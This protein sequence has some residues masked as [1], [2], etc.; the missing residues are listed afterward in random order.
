MIQETEKLKRRKGKQCHFFMLSVL[1]LI[2]RFPADM[3]RICFHARQDKDLIFICLHSYLQFATDVNMEPASSFLNKIEE[4]HAVIKEADFMLN[5]LLK[6]NENA[7]Q[8]TVTWR[9]TGEELMVERASL[10]KEV[11]QLKSALCLKD[12]ENELLCDQ[13]HYALIEVNQSISSLEETFLQMQRDAEEQFSVTYS[14]VLSM[15]QEMLCCIGNSRSSLEDVCSEMMEKGFASF[16]LYQCHLSEFFQKIQSFKVEPGHLPFR[17]Q[18]CQSLGL[19]TKNDIIGNGK[20][21]TKEGKQ[22]VAE[23]Y[24]EGGD[25]GLTHDNLIFENMSLKKELEKKEDLLKGLLFDFTLLQE[26]ASNTKDFKD[27]T[28]KL[29]L[30]LSQARHELERKTCQL[31]DVL[32]QHRNL[33]G[34]AA[35]A[36]AAICI[37]SSELDKAREMI[38]MLSDQN[39]DL[40]MVLKDLY[41]N[42]TEVEEQLEEQKEAVKGFEKEILRLTSPVKKKFLSSVE[43]IEDE[44]SRVTSERDQLREEVYCMADKLEMAHALADENEAVAV[45]ARQVCI[46][47]THILFFWYHKYV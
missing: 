5:A 39:A 26:S 8:L 36:E 44:L 29:I 38:V 2:D 27:E 9:K 35:E 20:K 4:A 17:R 16:V 19:S 43:D 21:S 40:R 32:N 34:R 11:E 33:E 7:K 1:V 10:M 47:D 28:E 45:E 23:T 37:S 6:A 24:L 41:F 25:K 13:F 12:K 46:P 30:A 18:E 3:K 42:K 14:N 22:S 31:D 15:A